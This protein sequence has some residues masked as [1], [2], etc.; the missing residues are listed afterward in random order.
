M[1]TP[2]TITAAPTQHGP[3]TLTVTGEIDIS[4][5]AV[6]AAAIEA[7]HGPLIIELT[8]VHYLDSAGLSVLFTHAPRLEIVI[9]ALLAPVIAIAGLGAVAQVHGPN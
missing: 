7:Q 6:L 3:T 4:N 9:P 8:E 2:L 1:A 5:A